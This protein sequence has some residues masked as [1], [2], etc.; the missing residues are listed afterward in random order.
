MGRAIVCA[1]I[2]WSKLIVAPVII[3]DSS[4][5]RN[6]TARATSVGS[7]KRPFGCCAAASS[8]QFSALPWYSCCVRF[9]PSDAIQPMFN[10]FTRMRLRSSA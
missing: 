9:S 5:D 8:S 2:A 4:Q 7:S 1:Q 6:A 10:P 3:P